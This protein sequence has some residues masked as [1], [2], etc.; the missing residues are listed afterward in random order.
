[1]TRDELAKIR[2]ELSGGTY[3]A[4]ANGRYDVARL[5]AHVEGLEKAARLLLGALPRCGRCS[6]A[7]THELGG[8]HDTTVYFCAEHIRE[9]WPTWSEKAIASYEARWFDAAR[10]LLAAL[11]ET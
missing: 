3:S 8:G 10:A 5:L 4:G 11:G 9:A 6:C 1:M 7:A 2:A